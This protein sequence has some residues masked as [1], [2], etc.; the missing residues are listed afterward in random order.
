MAKYGSNKV[1]F[2]LI[3]GYDVLGVSTQITDEIEADIEETTSLGDDWAKH[4]YTDLRRA[5]LSQEG[6]FDDATDSSHD[7]LDAGIGVERVLCY[8][9]TGNEIGQQ[10]TGYSGAL[11]SSYTKVASRGELHRANAS[12]LGAGQVDEGVILHSHVSTEGDDTEDDAVDNETSSEDGVAYLQVSEL[13]DCD[14]I[15]VN[16]RESSGN[17]WSTLASFT[18]VESAPDSERI[19]IEGSIE[20]YLAVSWSFTNAGAEPS[21]KFMVGLRRIVDE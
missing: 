19:E 9:V 18:A 7:A 5:E 4:E 11:Q 16:I 2:F 1:G 3:D 8:N 20:R 14:S 6:Y 17:G 15:T 13:E 21:A 10:F 12:Y